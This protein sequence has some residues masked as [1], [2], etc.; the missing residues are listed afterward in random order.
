MTDFIP[1]SIPSRVPPG[2]WEVEER[3]L[4]LERDTARTNRSRVRWIVIALLVLSVVLG[5]VFRWQVVEVHRSD[6]PSSMYLVNR[7]TGEMRY[8]QFE[9][10]MQVEKEK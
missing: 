1:P 4:E 7:W 3:R 6:R 8:V 10:W 2:G 9:V 5:W